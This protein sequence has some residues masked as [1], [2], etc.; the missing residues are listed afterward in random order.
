MHFNGDLQLGKPL[1]SLIE[2]D[3]I[4]INERIEW[5]SPNNL[6][7]KARGNIVFKKEGK[8]IIKTNASVYLKAGLEDPSGAGTVTFEDRGPQ[9]QLEGKGKVFIYYNPQ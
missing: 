6:I 5:D 4:Y 2:A 9:L 1:A 8:L 3:N 7:L